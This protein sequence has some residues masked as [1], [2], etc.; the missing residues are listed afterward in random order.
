MTPGVIILFFDVPTKTKPEQRAYRLLAKHLE[1]EGYEPI[2]KSIYYKQI[3]N[4]RRCQA[5]IEA[6]KRATKDSGS[7]KAIILT[8]P[9]FDAI[10]NIRGEPL[11]LNR[12]SVV[13]I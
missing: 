2:Q 10:V 3:R 9:Q 12:E 13:V 5:N 11:A 7:I 6:L 8:Y 1:Q 4:I